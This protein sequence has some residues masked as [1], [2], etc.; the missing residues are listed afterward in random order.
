MTVRLNVHSV[1]RQHVAYVLT[2][3]DSAPRR[4]SMRGRWCSAYPPDHRNCT[5]VLCTS[6]P[7]QAR[8]AKRGEMVGACE[9][10]RTYIAY[11]CASQLQIGPLTPESLRQVF[12]EIFN[13]RL[14]FHTRRRCSR[15]LLLYGWHC[16]LERCD[17]IFTQ[18]ARS[19]LRREIPY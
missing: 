7:G 8:M 15:V 5:A 10:Q 3:S 11:F 16:L 1:R 12:K 19:F 2:K 6:A 13:D 14:F 18:C 17:P 4:G 9:A